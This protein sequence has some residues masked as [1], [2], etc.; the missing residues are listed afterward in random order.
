MARAKKSA[1]KSS[2]KHSIGIIIIAVALIAAIVVLGIVYKSDIVALLNKNENTPGGQQTVTNKTSVLGG[3][4]AV[5]LPVEID[6][7]KM[8]VHFIDVGQGDAIV[9]RF[10]DGKDIIVDAGSGA[11]RNAPTAI[12]TQFLEYLE[13]INIDKFD[14][15]FATHHHSDHMNLLDDVLDAYSVTNIYY[16]G[17]EEKPETQYFADF[18]A[19]VAAENAEVVS[20]DADGDTYVIQGEGYTFTVYAPGY[21]AFPEDTNYM[22]P[23]ILVE[24]AGK[25]VLLT[26]DSEEETETWFYQK[27]GSETPDIDV[28]KVGHHGSAKG[29][30]TAFLD[31]VKPEFAVISVGEK[32]SY[33]HPTPATMN[34]LFNYG[35]VTYRT[36][37]HG[38]IIMYVDADGDF[39]FG[40]DNEVPV[41]NNKNLINDRMIITKEA[42]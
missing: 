1:A 39:A 26:G 38:N 15:M 17:Y 18:E 16:N 32:N 28:L 6:E 11:S 21:G 25:R 31:K 35:I 42:A 27:L 14:Y 29:T 41:E 13:S 37:R 4:T 40:V 8:E 5:N 3:S 36:N 9:V 24:C 7:I 34:D 12:K 33:N 10:S 30:S 23:F 20:F 22:S 2:T 19:K